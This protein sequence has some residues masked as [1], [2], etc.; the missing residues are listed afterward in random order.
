MHLKKKKAEPVLVLVACCM[1]TLYCVPAAGWPGPTL[2]P[3]LS[4]TRCRSQI[5]VGAGGCSA[6]VIVSNGGE[7][8]VYFLL[9]R[10]FVCTKK[11][12]GR[13]VIVADEFTIKDMAGSTVY[14]LLSHCIVTN[15]PHGD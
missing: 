9:T 15:R 4:N 6:C 3:A 2:A 8:G 11:G 1:Y 13:V 14:P 12:E 7:A 5:A 10:V